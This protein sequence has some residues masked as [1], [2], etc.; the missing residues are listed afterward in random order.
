L[1]DEQVPD[2]RERIDVQRLNVRNPKCVLGQ[3]YGA[4]IDGHIALGLGPILW[5]EGM[6]HGFIVSLNDSGTASEVE[7]CWREHIGQP[8]AAV[9]S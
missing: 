6:Y 2:W 4:Y 9:V 5:L 1:L 3:L 7:A 8:V